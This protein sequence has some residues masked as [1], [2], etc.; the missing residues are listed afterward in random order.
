MGYI[1]ATS[2]L[3]NY[4]TEFYYSATENYQPSL[5][6]ISLF[7]FVKDPKNKVRQVL[8]LFSPPA[9]SVNA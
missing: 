4:K 7:V 5:Q 9:S 2:P 3:G 6:W 1:P 8:T